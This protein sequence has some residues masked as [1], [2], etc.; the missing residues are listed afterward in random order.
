MFAT[1][2][3]NFLAAHLLFWFVPLARAGTPPGPYVNLTLFA[4]AVVGLVC[5]SFSGG[6]PSSEART[7][8]RLAQWP[9]IT[10]LS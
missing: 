10:T 8:V 2:V 1:L 4:L 5:G 6:C 3:L 9:P 7:R